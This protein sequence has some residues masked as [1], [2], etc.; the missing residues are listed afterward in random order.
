MAVTINVR[1]CTAVDRTVCCSI[2]GGWMFDCKDGFILA[3]MVVC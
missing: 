1:V 2:L 3:E